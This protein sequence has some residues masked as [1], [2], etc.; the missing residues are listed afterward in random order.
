M[1]EIKYEIKLND[2]G[3]PCIDLPE[4][5]ENKPEDKFF[6]M[7]LSRYILTNVY[8]RKS[9]EYDPDDANKLLFC[10]NFL[11]QISDEMAA[12]IYGQMES[13]GD[14]AVT[15]NVGHHISVENIEERDAIPDKGY[16]YEGK[17]FNRQEGLKVFVMGELKLFK[18]QGGITNDNWIEYK[19]ML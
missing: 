13:M 1:F 15:M 10:I 5:Y 2:R 3:R 7:E 14:I 12:L 8:N 17:I 18:L 6:V 4:E 19:I 9:A 16:L 11:G